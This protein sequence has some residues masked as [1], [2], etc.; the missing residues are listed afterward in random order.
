MSTRVCHFKPG[1]RAILAPLGLQINR[2]ELRARTQASLEQHEKNRLAAEVLGDF[3][4]VRIADNGIERCRHI[5]SI[6]EN[7]RAA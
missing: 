5:L 4:G 3:E 6:T 7:R 2:E 1:V